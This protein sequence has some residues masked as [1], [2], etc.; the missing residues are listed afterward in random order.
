M[1]KFMC[2]FF[3]GFQHSAV[4]IQPFLAAELV[5]LQVEDV[6]VEGL[7]A[8]RLILL[9]A[10]CSLVGLDGAQVLDTRLGCTRSG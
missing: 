10:P 9:C 8:T 5:V 3:C 6:L 7:L 1:C 2:D 4:S